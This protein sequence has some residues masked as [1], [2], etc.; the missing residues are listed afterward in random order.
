[1]LLSTETLTGWGGF[2]IAK[3]TSV[4]TKEKKREGGTRG[5]TQTLY[6]H[7]KL[8][9]DNFAKGKIKTSKDGGGKHR[10]LNIV[11]AVHLLR[12]KLILVPLTEPDAIDK[13]SGVH[14]RGGSRCF[15][16]D[17]FPLVDINVKDRNAA[18][19]LVDMAQEAWPSLLI[20]TSLDESTCLLRGRNSWLAI[21]DTIHGYFLSALLQRQQKKRKKRD[22]EIQTLF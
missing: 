7:S 17:G 21:I 15:R 19:R 11:W 12:K 13:L 2:R 3:T 20:I 10:G 1:M 18:V 14:L 8:T 16:R 6:F 4:R 22:F 5:R 9:D